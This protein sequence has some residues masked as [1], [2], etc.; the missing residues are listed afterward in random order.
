MGRRGK[1]ELR[2]RYKSKIDSERMDKESVEKASC[3]EVEKDVQGYG[4]FGGS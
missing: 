3:R 2:R 1:K 4:M